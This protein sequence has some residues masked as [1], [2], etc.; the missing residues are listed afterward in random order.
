MPKPRNLVGFAKDLPVD[1]MERLLA[2]QVDVSDVGMRALALQ[3][4]AAV[5]DY[6]AAHGVPA[7][8]MFL[9]AVRIE[10]GDTPGWQPAAQLRL[11]A[12]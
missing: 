8:R 2:G 3:R 11:S 7:A 4:G 5:R 6:L 12:P 1:E 10:D 9:G